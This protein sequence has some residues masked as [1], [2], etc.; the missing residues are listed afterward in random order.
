MARSKIV[1]QRI[2]SPDGKTIVGVR[3]M[4]TTSNDSFDTTGTSS[5]Q[6]VIVQSFSSGSFSYSSVSYSD[7]TSTNQP[8]EE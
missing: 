5:Q 7:S 1:I 8:E 4:A 6:K 3:G 2:T